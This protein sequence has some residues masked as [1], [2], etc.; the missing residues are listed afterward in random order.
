M[1]VYFWYFCY[2][3]K[4]VI[5][6]IGGVK[7]DLDVLLNILRVDVMFKSMGF[8]SIFVENINN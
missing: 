2:M 6:K 7:Q 8:I 1:R 4:C 3:V 5:R